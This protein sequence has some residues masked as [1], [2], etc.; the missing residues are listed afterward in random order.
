MVIRSQ[1]F[2]ALLGGIVV[3]YSVLSL[4]YVATSPDV[5]LRTLLVDRPDDPDI[6]AGIVIR[7]VDGLEYRG[8][9]RP[10]AGD[11]LLELA[12]QPT[13]T[14]IHFTQQVGKLRGATTYPGGQLHAGAD[15]GELPDSSLPPLVE[16][17]PDER[18]VK[19]K[20][21]SQDDGKTHTCWLQVQSLPSGEVLFLLVWF[22]L[23]LCVFV[24]AGLAYWKRPTD[25]TS[26]L[27]YLMC[28]AVLGS[29]V[30]CYHWWIVAESFWLTMG[31][32]LCAIL[33]P[34]VTLHFFLVFPRT[35]GLLARYPR[36]GTT[37]LYLPAAVACTALLTQLGYVTWLYDDADPTHQ[38]NEVLNALETFRLWIYGCF[39]GAAVYFLATISVVYN[40]YRGTRQPLERNQ[41]K[42]I[43]WAACVAGVLVAGT[44]FLAVHDR[45]TFALGPGAFPCSWRAF[46]SCWPMRWALFAT[47]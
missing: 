25:R 3:V 43:W 5:R 23:H 7:P 47:S 33:V 13:P 15:V 1:W 24:V 9:S 22:V 6:A 17:G 10:V 16:V 8:P 45:A 35:A 20:Y 19:V 4:G 31:Y 42:W 32:A 34:V 28:T 37:S 11:I 38:I 44:L 46:R 26:L 36:L 27:F 21:L 18:W 39:G 29:F 41:L 12:G 2:L 40:S 30:G 14:F